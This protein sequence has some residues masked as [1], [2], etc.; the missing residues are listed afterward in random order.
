VVQP[1]GRLAVYYG[2]AD[3]AIGVATT[4]LPTT[5]WVKRET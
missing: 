3:Q 4:T 5:D 1:D 2:M